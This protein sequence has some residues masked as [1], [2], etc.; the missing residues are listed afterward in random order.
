MEIWKPIKGYEGSYEVSD[1]GRVKSF[2]KKEPFIMK[3]SIDKWG[4]KTITL[5]KGRQR[6]WFIHRL[7]LLMF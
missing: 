3:Q 4:Y 1:M 2:N 7:V 5:H 6:S